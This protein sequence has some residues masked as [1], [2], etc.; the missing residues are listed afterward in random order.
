MSCYIA[1][2]ALH[3]TASLTHYYYTPSCPYARKGAKGVKGARGYPGLPGI[4]GSKG[5]QGVPGQRGHKG[6]GGEKGLPGPCGL[7][8]DDGPTGFDGEPGP[9]GLPGPIGNREGCPE[10]DGIDLGLV[11]YL[12]MC[13]AVYA[14]LCNNLVHV[15]V[16]MHVAMFNYVS[17]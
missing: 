5:L 4:I 3:Y 15:S 12:S 13:V 1:S 14:Q 8:G 10:F 11:S 6:F 17:S 7:H 2:L 16:F 9:P